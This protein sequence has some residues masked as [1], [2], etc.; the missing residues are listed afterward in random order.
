MTCYYCNKSGDYSTYPLIY[1]DWSADLIH[2]CEECIILH[3]VPECCG[4][5][6]IAYN[7]KYIKIIEDTLVYACSPECS[8]R[9]ITKKRHYFE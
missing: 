6:S 9:F 4:C 1:S 2:I 5:G 8:D 3:I 7:D